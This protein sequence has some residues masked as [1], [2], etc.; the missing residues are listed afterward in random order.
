MSSAAAGPSLRRFA[1]ERPITLFL[2]IVFGLGYPLMFVP[3]LAHWGA[4]PL[5]TLPGGLE[6]NTEVIASLALVLLVLLPA[7]LIVTGLEGGRPAMAALWRRATQWRFGLGWWALVLAA[8]PLGTVLLALALGDTFRPPSLTGLADEFVAIVV[9]LVLIQIIEETA[10]A[11]FLQTRLERRHGF[12]LAALL[13]AI[14]FAAIHMPL[15]VIYQG[16]DPR[17]MATTFGMLTAF[18]FVFRAY[19]GLVLRGA[20]NSVLAVALAHTMFN[21]SNNPGGIAADLLDGSH[22]VGAVLIMN[23]AL[24]LVLGV[25]LRKRTSRAERARLDAATDDPA[26]P[27][28]TGAAL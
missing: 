26:G 7:P 14:P 19:L 11:G 13:T 15:Q 1:R 25:A 4:E 10:W 20:G 18:A 6:L 12:Y 2:L 23:V 28:G 8:L 9:A 22:R 27:M 17:G 5:G 24:V 3:I 21:R 16:F